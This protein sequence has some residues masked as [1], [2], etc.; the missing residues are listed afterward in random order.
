M[1][2]FFVLETK[3]PIDPPGRASMYSLSEPNC[4]VLYTG[5]VIILNY[6]AYI[7]LMRFCFCF[8]ILSYFTVVGEIGGDWLRGCLNY[9]LVCL[10]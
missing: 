9:M 4:E 8:L 1:R 7:C 6:S 5:L 2:E 10:F 3:T